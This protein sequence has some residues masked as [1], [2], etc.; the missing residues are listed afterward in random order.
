MLMAV[1]GAS[2]FVG[3]NLVQL[4]LDQGHQ[5]RAIDRL[6]SPYL[7]RPGVCWMDGDVLNADSMKRALEGVDQV[8]HLVAKITLAEEDEFAWTLNTKGVRN[9]AEAALAN[10]VKRMIHCSSIAAFDQFRCGGRMDE[11]SPRSTDPKLPVYDRSKFAGEQELREVI[12]KGLDG[13]I[14]NPTGVY[15]PV[16]HSYS[17]INDVL[18]KAALGQ[19]P[20][21]FTGAFD[22]V[23]VR[24][25]AKGFILAGEHGRTG[26]NYLIGGHHIPTLEIMRMAARVLG[27]KGPAFA[28]PIGVV[29]LCM[30]LIERLS[31]G[32]GSDALS[33]RSIDAIECAP[34]VDASKAA[35]EL[36]YVPRPADDTVRELMAFLVSSNQMARARS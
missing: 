34:V 6:Q 4:L 24:D 33:K 8:F 5:V 11:T 22:W 32:S 29:K 19:I 20:F 31:K 12:A 36:H 25:V 17:R 14:C 7:Q 28:L 21:V 16:D 3:L 26:E 15:G 13:V 27:R 2:G 1:T 18:R 30:P 23:D 10:G 35:R 9:V